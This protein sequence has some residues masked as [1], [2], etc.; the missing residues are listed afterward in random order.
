MGKIKLKLRSTDNLKDDQ[1]DGLGVTSSQTLNVTVLYTS[2]L[3]FLNSGHKIAVTY[4][5]N[6]TEKI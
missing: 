5:K 3:S 2:A 6:A 1:N 4:Q